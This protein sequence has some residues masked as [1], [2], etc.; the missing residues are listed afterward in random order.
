MTTIGRA[1]QPSERD[2]Q[3]AF[4]SYLRFQYPDVLFFSVPNGARLASGRGPR[5]NQIAAIR[6]R[7]LL[8]EGALPGVSDLII[9]EPR[10]GYSAM[11]LEMKRADGGNGGSEKQSDFLLKVEQRG[12][13]GVIADGCDDAC[14]W[15]DDYLNNKI[16]KPPANKLPS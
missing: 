3:V 12:G 8:A 7:N 11:F 16:V 4:V 15:A 2:E 10:G 9:Y 14:K 6:W 13:F 5:A 1:M